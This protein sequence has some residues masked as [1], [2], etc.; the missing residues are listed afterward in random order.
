MT[1]SQTVL[2]A[3]QPTY[4][5]LL[6][7]LLS[8]E[9][10]MPLFSLPTSPQ[11]LRQPQLRH[12]IANTSVHPTLEAALHILNLDLPAAHFLL[13]HMQD[14]GKAPEAAFLHGI[15]HRIEGDIDNT[16]AWYR[17]TLEAEGAV[18]DAAWPGADGKQQALDFLQSVEQSRGKVHATDDLQ[19]RSLEELKSVVQFCEKRFGTSKLKDATEAWVDMGD[20]HR[21]KAGDMMVGGEGWREF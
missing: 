20:E 21:K 11:R 1:A 13:R 15:L 12:Q 2:D 6:D 8:S 7:Q 10:P 9:P 16:R 14:P 17:L 18:F 5:T 19:I 3:S 4:K